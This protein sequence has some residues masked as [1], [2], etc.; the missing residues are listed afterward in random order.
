MDVENDAFT[1]NDIICLTKVIGALTE[2]LWFFYQS[3]S[4]DLW[5]IEYDNGMKTKF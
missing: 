3:F 1:L 2:D 5:T 4:D